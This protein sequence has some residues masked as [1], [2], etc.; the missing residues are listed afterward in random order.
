MVQTIKLHI[1][2]LSALVQ[3]FGHHPSSSGC[4]KPYYGNYVKSKCN[5]SDAR[6]TLSRCNLVMEAFRAILERLLQ[7]TVQMLGQAIRTPS[8]I[9][10]ITFYSN[11]GLGQNWRRW[12][13][14]KKCCKMIV[15]KANIRVQKAPIL[16]E[17]Y[18][19]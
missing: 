15:W 13:G 3:P 17:R 18:G 4:S 19:V 1:W 6:A 12:K 14:N 8:G 16:T 7:L 11:I 5:H 2:K 10:I 9:L